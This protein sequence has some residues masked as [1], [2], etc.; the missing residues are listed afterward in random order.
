MKSNK[1][2]KIFM[3]VRR[4][5]RAFA[6]FSLV[7]LH[8]AAWGQPKTLTILHTN[9][10]H[11]SFMPH[12]AFWIRTTPRPMVGGFAELDAVVDSIRHVNPNTLLLDAGDVMTGNP[13]TD[14]DYRGAQ[15]GWLF[16]FMNRIGYE[17]GTPGN[18]DFDISQRN[19]EA[20]TRVAHF[21][22]VS[23]N[24]HD[25][26]GRELGACIP[27]TVVMKNGLRIGIVG[28]MSRDF[29]NLV[30]QR[31]TAGIRLDTAVT[32]LQAIIDTLDQKADLVI[33]LTHEG[34]D[35]DTILAR[36]VHGLDLIVGGHSHTRLKHPLSVNGVVIVQ[37]G[38]NCENLGILTLTVED[39]RITK[40]D[41]Y[42][43]Q[44]WVDGSRPKSPIASLAD[45]LQGVID[46]SYAKVIGTLKTEWARRRGE[47]NVGDFVSDAQREATGADVAFMNTAGIRA[48][49]P[50][51]PITRRM[52]FEVLPFR[53]TVVTFHL[54]GAQI[55]AIVRHLLGDGTRHDESVQTS[56]IRCEW[57]PT[58]DGVEI[59]TLEINGKPIDDRKEY[60]GAAND[61]MMGES[62]RYLGLKAP[63]LTDTGLTL[64]EVVEQKIRTEQTIDARV[65][66]RIRRVDE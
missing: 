38:S 6:V 50:A 24:L 29:Y 44:L 10:M 58:P 47:S 36:R 49:V 37:A 35:D 57:K 45:S 52:L 66:H 65:E 41:G 54:S 9:D 48:D 34:V 63:L 55:R 7:A 19:F 53:N 51:G 40:Y 46:Q 62:V 25:T 21:P 60:L 11:A 3:L 22:V 64:F 28:W 56:G 61:Y 43:K 39:H 4:V 59:A 1:L 16:E 2:R 30:S 15:G 17:V 42:L 31:S 13:I 18:H 8:A 5:I 26:D 12:E 14:L 20:L 32:L 23:A 27:Y 33:A